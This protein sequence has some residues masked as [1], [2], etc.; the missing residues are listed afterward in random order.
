MCAARIPLAN[1]EIEALVPIFFR[2]KGAYVIARVKNGSEWL[3]LVLPLLHGPDGIAI[4]AVLMTSDEVSI[5]F[6]FSWSYFFVETSRPRAVVEFLASIMPL[7]SVVGLGFRV[8]RRHRRRHSL[9][10]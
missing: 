1:S 6:G 9:C 7:K 3:P 2:N 10:G 8:G 5:V 4:D